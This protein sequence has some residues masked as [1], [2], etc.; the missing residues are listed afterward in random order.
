MS[1]VNNI[2]I[3]IKRFIGKVYSELGYVLEVSLDELDY[4][5]NKY[6]VQV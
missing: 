5:P 3:G 2:T 4:I 1:S 6:G